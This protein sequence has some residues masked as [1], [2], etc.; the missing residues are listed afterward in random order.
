[1]HAARVLAIP[2][3][4]RESRAFL[5]GSIQCG[6]VRN[7]RFEELRESSTRGAHSLFYPCS[8]SLTSNQRFTVIAQRL[9]G[10]KVFQ[11]T[12]QMSCQVGVVL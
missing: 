8:R 12:L 4:P 1:M 6:D 2:K 11:I 3:T 5:L 9:R 7:A 10:L